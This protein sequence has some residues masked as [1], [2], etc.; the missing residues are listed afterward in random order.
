MNGTTPMWS[1]FWEENSQLIKINMIQYVIL[2]KYYEKY[3][4]HI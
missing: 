1:Y 2:Q 4:Q 3:A